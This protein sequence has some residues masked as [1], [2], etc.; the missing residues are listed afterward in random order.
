M[1]SEFW[2]CLKCGNYL[3]GSYDEI[4][5]H[6]QAHQTICTKKLSE[7]ENIQKIING[8]FAFSSLLPP[9]P[10]PPP[11]PIPLFVQQG[12]KSWKTQLNKKDLNIPKE[13]VVPND[14]RSTMP[15][16]VVNELKQF[17]E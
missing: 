5:N 13:N 14:P 16:S 8:L 10:P 1:N 7:R 6:S 15:V 4:T 3:K 11:P 12:K 2:A 9:T 17:I